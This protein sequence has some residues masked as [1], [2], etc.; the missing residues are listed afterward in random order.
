MSQKD[1]SVGR[2]ARPLLQCQRDFFLA[3][4]DLLKDEDRPIW[5]A[6]PR[7]G[8][9]L[10]RS[11]LR[12]KEAV[13]KRRLGKAIAP[14]IEASVASQA[15]TLNLA[16]AARSRMLQAGAKVT[17]RCADAVEGVLEKTKE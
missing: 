15:I 3:C 16:V 2:I 9:A 8:N 6:L 1:K 13:E 14:M 12:I 5:A 4:E 11:Q 10:G 7:L 17:R